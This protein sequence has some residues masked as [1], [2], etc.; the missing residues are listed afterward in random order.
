M[1]KFQRSFRKLLF[2]CFE[3]RWAAVF[4]AIV[5]WWPQTLPFHSHW[6]IKSRSVKIGSFVVML[7]LERKRCCRKVFPKSGITFKKIEGDLWQNSSVE[8]SS[9]KSRIIREFSL[10]SPISTFLEVILLRFPGWNPYMLNP[11]LIEKKWA[12]YVLNCFWA[13]KR[14][15]WLGRKS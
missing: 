5:I 10:R 7:L 12:P 11:A 13:T 3:N 8:P 6:S 14:R 2:S 9:M 4:F 15:S 1:K